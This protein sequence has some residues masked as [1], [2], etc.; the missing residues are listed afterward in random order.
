MVKPEKMTY[1]L[2]GYQYIEGQVLAVYQGSIQ[3]I[4]EFFSIFVLHP[5]VQ[6]GERAILQT[7]SPTLEG[8]KGYG[9]DEQPSNRTPFQKSEYKL[10]RAGIESV[11]LWKC[12]RR[13]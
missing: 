10:I 11:Q 9:V 12:V 13:K 6:E 3:V 5:H 2:S 7:L 4:E 1:R 8:E